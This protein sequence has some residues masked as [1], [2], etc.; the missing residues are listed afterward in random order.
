[1][2]PLS[3]D[4]SKMDRRLFGTSLGEK[5]WYRVVD[6]ANESFGSAIIGV[7]TEYWYDNNSSFW[8]SVNTTYQN[9]KI[10]ELS[11]LENVAD[12]ITGARITRDATTQDR[13]FEIYYNSVQNN[14]VY[15]SILS[16][17]GLSSVKPINFEISPSDAVV[18]NNLSL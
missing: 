12:I 7:D 14:Y 8:F 18:L 2:I 17:L 5:G 9:G 13:Y 4:K 6:F 15:I 16:S 3:K 11:R 10:T 1:M